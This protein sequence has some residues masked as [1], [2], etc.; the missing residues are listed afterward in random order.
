MKKITIITL[1]LIA[2]F[3]VNSNAQITLKCVKPGEE[4][5][6]KPENDTLWVMN[7]IRMRH[8]I[9][10]GR[11]YKLEQDKNALLTQKCDTL[12]SIIN[13]QDQLLSTVKDDR[14]Y[15]STELAT[16]RDNVDKVGAIAQKYKRRT[17]I[18][19]T[20]TIVGTIA[21]FVAGALIFR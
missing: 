20:T 6:V 19:T 14:N 11:K 17:K 1:I 8:V 15:Y 4:L 5:L 3:A 10:T 13:E 18:A 12:Q 9:E 16:C 21:G 2:F 7:D